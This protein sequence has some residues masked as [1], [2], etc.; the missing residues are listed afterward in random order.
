MEF[1]IS[2]TFSFSFSLPENDIMHP[3]WNSCSQSGVDLFYQ[4]SLLNKATTSVGSLLPAHHLLLI[5]CP[6]SRIRTVVLLLT[7][8]P[9]FKFST[10]ATRNINCPS[11]SS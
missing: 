11:R 3:V 1:V 7:L 4:N 5:P 9:N 6:S 2:M 8:S 10:L